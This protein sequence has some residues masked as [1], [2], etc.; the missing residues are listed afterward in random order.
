MQIKVV[1][2]TYRQ[3]YNGENILEGVLFIQREVSYLLKLIGLLQNF[4]LL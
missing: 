4:W 1:K 3:I 2:M